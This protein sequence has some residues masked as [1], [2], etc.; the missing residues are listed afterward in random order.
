MCINT[1]AHPNAARRTQQPR[2]PA[3]FQKNSQISSTGTE[4]G[5]HAAFTRI[6][7]RGFSHP[8]LLKYESQYHWERVAVVPAAKE[9]SITLN[10]AQLQGNCFQVAF[11]AAKQQVQ[12]RWFRDCRQH[13]A[14][15]G[16]D[17]LGR[18]LETIHRLS[19][20][21]FSGTFNIKQLANRDHQQRIS[22]YQL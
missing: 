8:C 20:D 21:S 6:S 16:T 4:S 11:A 7:T 13:A 22:L 19:P 18:V 2:Q 10:L 1:A 14:S 3:S 12:V 5:D 15:Q 17:K 9:R